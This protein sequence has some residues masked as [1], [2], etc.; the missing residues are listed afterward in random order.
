MSIDEQ[1]DAM[2]AQIRASLEDSTLVAAMATQALEDRGLID[3]AEL[4]EREARALWTLEMQG[5]GK[6]ES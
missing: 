6:K 5:A 3:G 2:I 4:T 1:N